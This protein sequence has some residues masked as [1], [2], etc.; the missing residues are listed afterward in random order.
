M[1]ELHAYANGDGTYQVAFIAQCQDGLHQFAVPDAVIQMDKIVADETGRQT[2]KIV[3]NSRC[4][5]NQE[6]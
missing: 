4:M 5:M 1:Q 6:A 3:M 2:I